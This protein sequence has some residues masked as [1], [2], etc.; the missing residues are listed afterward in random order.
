MNALYSFLEELDL[1]NA[2]EARMRAQADAGRLQEAEETA[3]LWEILCG[4]LDQ[5]V[6]ILGDEPMET[7]E[8]SRLLRQV[9]GQYSVGTIRCLWTRCPS[10][11]S[12][13]TTGTRTSTCSSWGQRPCAAGRRPERRHPQR[14]RPGGAGPAWHPSGASGMEQMGIEL[15]NLYA[16]LAQ[17]TEGLTVSY[18]AADVTGAELRPAFVVDRAAG[19]VPGG[20]GGGGS[21]WIGPT[22]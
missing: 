21:L 2:L 19:P 11:R 18:P 5:F 6:E 1:Q 22:G 9:A 12:P 17:P 4:V 10:P 13:E 20:A 15:Q 8:F 16:A 14:R 3:Q 7:D